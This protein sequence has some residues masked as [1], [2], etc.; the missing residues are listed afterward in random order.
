MLPMI[1]P[2]PLPV[3]KAHDLQ[4][5]EDEAASLVKDA[6]AV[7]DFALDLDRTDLAACDA[8][9]A[10]VL[11]HTESALHASSLGSADVAGDA[12]DFGVVK[13]VYD[14]LVIRP[15]Q[16]KLCV[17]GAG[18]AALRASDDPHAEQDHDQHNDGS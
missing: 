8:G 9:V 11:G 15:Q 12:I 14:D 17:D 10:G 16:P 4:C 3:E 7:L 5:L 13:T 2:I 6:L 18:S 1:L